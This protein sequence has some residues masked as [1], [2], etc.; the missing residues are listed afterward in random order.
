LPFFDFAG[1]V[2]FHGQCRKREE[3]KTS[4][5]ALPLGFFLCLLSSDI[6]FPHENVR[7][8]FYIYSGI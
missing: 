4:Q 1:D 6:Q 3:E 8:C 7:T 5:I 2:T